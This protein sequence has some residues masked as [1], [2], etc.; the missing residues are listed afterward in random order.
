MLAAAACGGKSPSA[1]EPPVGVQ[2]GIIEFYDLSTEVRALAS[3][4]LGDT[5]MITVTTYG[6]WDCIKFHS[7]E[8]RTGRL[9]I[10]VVPLDYFEERTGTWCVDVLVPIEHEARV[11]LLDCG[12]AKVRIRG[13]R[14]PE[15]RLITVDRE[16]VVR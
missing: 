10:E 8:V 2:P 1:A 12:T 9:S 4:S 3:A 15:N 14:W 7:T 16:I 11:L 6:D 13:R 5:V